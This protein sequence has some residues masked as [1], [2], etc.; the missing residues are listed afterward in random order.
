VIP[1]RP[2]SRVIV[3]D[4]LSFASSDEVVPLQEL[5]ARLAE[6][7]RSSGVR[8]VVLAAAC[9]SV[10]LLG[11]LA[12]ALTDKDVEVALVIAVD[13]QVV[14]PDSVAETLVRLAGKLGGTQKRTGEEAR[15]IA[16]QP[17]MRSAARRAGRLLALCLDQYIAAGHAGPEE[18][19]VLREEVLPRYV[20][21]VSFLLSARD[22]ENL[23]AL[24]SV[25]VLTGQRPVDAPILFGAA[26]LVRQQHFDTGGVPA[27][28]HEPLGAQLRTL[29]TGA[30]W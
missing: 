23:P 26:C 18:A 20:A 25:H 5:A 15:A 11:P 28:A 16:E 3:L 8:R 1:E 22:R 6:S 30:G 24:E 21:W 17:D 4:P 9:G 2:S 29:V 13:P 14:A 12:A 19:V 10:V 7:V 27:L